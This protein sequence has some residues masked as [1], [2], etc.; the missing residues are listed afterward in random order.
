[1]IGIG[2]V[3]ED[4]NPECLAAERAFHGAPRGAFLFAIAAAQAV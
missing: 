4:G 2:G 3:I 1:M